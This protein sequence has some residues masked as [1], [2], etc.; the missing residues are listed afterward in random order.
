MT[1]VGPNARIA[2]LAAAV[3]GAALLAYLLVF[4]S[5]PPALVVPAA[6]SAAPGAAQAAQ[7]APASSEPA[8]PAE[9]AF[10]L[11]E[12]VGDV[13]VLRGGAWVPLVGGD[14]LLAS[15]QV[16]TGPNGRA[17]LHDPA[18]TELVLRERVQLEVRE[19][20]QTVT[21]LTL[22][23]GK[24]RAAPAPGSERFEIAAGKARALAPAGS[25]FTIYA[26][27]RGAVAVASDQGTVDVVAEGRTVSLGERTQTVVEPGRAPR[28]PVPV[29][30]EVFLSVS[31]PDRELR[32]ARTTISGQV[33]PGTAVTVNGQEAAVGADGRFAAEVPLRDGKN[34]VEVSAEAVAGGKRTLRHGITTR[35]AGPPVEVDPSRMFDPAPPGTKP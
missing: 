20:T 3:L 8:A 23:R 30:D 9:A 2:L 33:A 13:E 34:Q 10:L 5:R 14:R 22:K 31:W 26:D 17:V 28:T 19:L 16:R 25:H 4:P 32:T 21:A 35:T 29:P 24:V 12:T 1:R 15:E 7:A 11:G 6:Q 18:G 27:A